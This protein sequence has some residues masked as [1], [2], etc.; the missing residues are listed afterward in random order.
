MHFFVRCRCPWTSRGEQPAEAGWLCSVSGVLHNA[1][2][3]R[4]THWNGWHLARLH[5]I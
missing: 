1:R 4:G 5:H 3:W 2:W